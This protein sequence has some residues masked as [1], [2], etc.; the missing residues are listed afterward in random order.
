MNL[1]ETAIHCT[2][3]NKTYHLK[4]R[5]YEKFKFEKEKKETMKIT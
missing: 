2:D 4:L 3:K 1:M 5:F